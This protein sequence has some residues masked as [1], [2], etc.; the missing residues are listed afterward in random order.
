MLQ[1]FCFKQKRGEVD[2]MTKSEKNFLNLSLKVSRE[3]EELLFNFLE[4]Q[5]QKVT[6][7]K[8]ILNDFLKR[9]NGNFFDISPKKITQTDIAEEIFQLLKAAPEHK[10]KVADLYNLVEKN[11]KIPTSVR[12]EVSPVTGENRFEKNVRFANLALKHMGILDPAPP[13]RGV[14]QLNKNFLDILLKCETVSAFQ[15]VLDGALVRK[16]LQLQES[17]SDENFEGRN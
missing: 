1:A 11:L 17:L 2:F 4:A 13:K 5:S 6:V 14:V 9:Y 15:G 16:Q 12:T 8:L 7:V 10:L 3:N